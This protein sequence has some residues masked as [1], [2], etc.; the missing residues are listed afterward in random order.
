M[1]HSQEIESNSSRPDKREEIPEEDILEA[2]PHMSTRE[3]EDLPEE[4]AEEEEREDIES[5]QYHQ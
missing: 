4:E 3:E 1:K 5:D 2:Q